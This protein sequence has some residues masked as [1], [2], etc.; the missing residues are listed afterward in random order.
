MPIRRRTRTLLWTLLALIVV[1]A[2]GFVSLLTVP[3]PIEHY[4]Q[5]RILLAL[6]EHYQTDVQLDNLRVTLIP[7]FRATGDN[8]VLPNRRP[9]VPP[10]ITVKHFTAEASTFE[11]LHD[12]VR[13]S[14]LKLDG[15]L[16]QVPP[17]GPQNPETK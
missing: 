17:K 13:L 3:A 6:R 15:L 5:G 2:I 4:L 10:L 14:W 16:I 11:L 12:P 8:F 7:F 9:G 1:L